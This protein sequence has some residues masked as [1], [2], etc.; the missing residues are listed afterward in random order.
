[1]MGK[2]LGLD[3]IAKEEK[4]LISRFEKILSGI[5]PD[6]TIFYRL[7]ADISNEASSEEILN[8][9]EPAFYH[10]LKSEEQDLFTNLITDYSKRRKNNKISPEDSR[11]MMNRNN[12]R[13]I[14]RNYLLHQATEEL[15]KGQDDLF[16]TLQ[17]AMKDPYAAKGYDE[18][19]QKR[20]KWAETKAGCSMLSCSS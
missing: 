16:I 15:G 18:L 10:P 5:Q 6:M 13:I 9:I 20:P 11:N 4:E 14:L 1:M 2:K 19:V 17:K 8:H 12:P 3:K 7:L